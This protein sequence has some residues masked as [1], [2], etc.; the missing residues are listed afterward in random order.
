MPNPKI[1]RR[2][3][4]VPELIAAA[5]LLAAGE[6]R[7]SD[8]DLWR[9]H[10]EMGADLTKVVLGRRDVTP[11]DPFGA[12]Y[13]LFVARPSAPGVN[14]RPDVERLVPADHPAIQPTGA[15]MAADLYAAIREIIRVGSQG[16]FGVEVRE[17]KLEPSAA[18]HT[19]EVILAL[20]D[21]L[22]PPPS[23]PTCLWCGKSIDYGRSTR[24]YCNDAHRMRG[25]RAGLRS[26]R[27]QSTVRADS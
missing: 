20:A 25:Y 18:D 13:T 1:P 9:K 2:L 24:T 26:G 6:I 7:Q 12:E 8:R 23:L 22:N 14:R 17:G 21:L 19:G 4:E 5:R 10:V 11:E 16:H 3:R 15:A 27:G